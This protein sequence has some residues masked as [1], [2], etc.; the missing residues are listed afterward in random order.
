[1][2]FM[3]LVNEIKFSVLLYFLTL[4]LLLSTLLTIEYPAG[5][6]SVYLKQTMQ[7]MEGKTQP[8]WVSSTSYVTMLLGM[9]IIKFAFS[10]VNL[11]L[12]MIIIT[13]F[14]APFMYLILREFNVKNS[15]AA[16]GSLIL[17]TSPHVLL[18]LG[19]FG[20]EPVSL[21]IYLL[22]LL[23][24]I[25]GIKLNSSRYLFAGSI[26]SIAGFLNK[27]FDAIPAIAA[28]IF[29]LL[30][31]RILDKI[32]L[33]KSIN[34]FLS[35]LE[36]LIAVKGQIEAKSLS[37]FL[38]VIIALIFVASYL[39]NNYIT[40]GQFTNPT[41]APSNRPH[42]LLSPQFGINVQSP[43]RIMQDTLFLGFFFLP[44]GLYLTKYLKP[45]ISFY[46]FE[47]KIINFIVL[48]SLIIASLATVSGEPFIINPNNKI[49]TFIATF[50]FSFTG[51]N[52]GL[53][54][55]ENRFVSKVINYCFI[56]LVLSTVFT[57]FKIGSFMISYYVIFLPLVLIFLTLKIKQWKPY[58][59]TI[60]ILGSFG[61][62]MTINNMQYEV[63]VWNKVEAALA[64][65]VKPWDIEGYYTVTVWLNNSLD[66]KYA[67]HVITW[68]RNPLFHELP[69]IDS[70]K[71]I[72]SV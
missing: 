55:F 44:F 28:F 18:Y 34:Y 70:I 47:F 51:V 69:D 66:N 19:Y 64:T 49:L 63:T 72:K 65:G 46:K 14:S 31:Y 71:I 15:L 23:F 36:N 42:P 29:L 24:F 4:I 48:F 5:N 59:M 50:L 53:F 62:F 7:L 30:Y 16:L 3:K 54:I 20:T 45:K 40:T 27:Q 57:F 22:S 35:S 10:F 2:S 58:L 37:K 33:Q 52:L 41:T 39:L 6:E 1:M 43:Y 56:V 60:L 25:R 17:M 8:N 13:A 32:K 12:L 11:R 26:F 67:K 61:I 9:P 38:A 21:P 68:E